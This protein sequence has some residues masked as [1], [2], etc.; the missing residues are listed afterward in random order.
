VPNQQAAGAIINHA[1]IDLAD[2]A[3]N[4]SGVAWHAL[5]YGDNYARLQR[6]KARWDPGNVFR[7][8]LSIEPVAG[9]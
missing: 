7:H 3:W 4:R 9:R 8:A 5:Y 2:P 6:I 1:D